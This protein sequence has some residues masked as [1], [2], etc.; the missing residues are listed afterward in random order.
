MR[1]LNKK[2][3]PFEHTDQ[4]NHITW[5]IVVS[6]LTVG[7]HPALIYNN[8]NC[9]AKKIDYVDQVQYNKAT[10]ASIVYTL[11]IENAAKPLNF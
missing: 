1:K 10:K 8:S 2:K 5:L 4:T 7:Q 9:L 6:S 11:K 3:K